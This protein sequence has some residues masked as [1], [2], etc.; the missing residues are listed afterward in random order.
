[1]LMIFFR[2]CQRVGIVVGMVFSTVSP[3]LDPPATA[4]LQ[5]TAASPKSANSAQLCL[6]GAPAALPTPKL[7]T[8]TLLTNTIILVQLSKFLSKTN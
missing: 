7:F 5:S 8:Y 6:G 4:G 1:M 2:P 3:A